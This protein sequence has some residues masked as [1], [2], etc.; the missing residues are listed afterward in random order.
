MKFRHHDL[1]IEL[2]DKW[3]SEAGMSQFAVST[4]SYITDEKFC[5]GRVMRQVRIDHIGPVHRAIGVGIFNDS[6]DE[7]SAQDRVTRIL[8]GFLLN[9]PIPPVEV[10]ENDSSSAYPF[11]LTHGSHRLYCSLAAGFTHVPAI[12]GFDFNS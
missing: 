1:E 5:R 10:V 9:Q 12:E 11:E 8:R 7:G 2:P 4:P 3:W 6:E